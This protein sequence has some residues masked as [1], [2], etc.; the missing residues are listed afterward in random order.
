MKNNRLIKLCALLFV[1]LLANC[2]DPSEGVIVNVNT[3]TLFKAP[4]LVRFENA[5]P[6]STSRIGDFPITITGKD[7][8]LVHMGTGGTD[9]KAAQGNLPL[10]LRSTAHPTDANPVTFTINAQIPGHEPIA[11]NVVLTSDSALVYVIA[12]FDSTNPAEGTSITNAEANLKSGVT[13][14]AVKLSTSTTTKLNETATITIPSGTEVRD[15]TNKLI[16]ADALRAIVT[17]YGNST[18]ALNVAFPNGRTTQNATDKEG[19]IIPYGVNYVPAGVVKIDMYAGKS[20]VAYFS[21][22]IEINQELPTGLINYETKAVVKLGEAIPLWLSFNQNG[23]YQLQKTSATVVAGPTGK[24]TAKYAITAAAINNLSW[25]YTIAPEPINSSLE[26][27]LNPSH[28][29]FTGNYTLNALNANNTYLFVVENYQ[30]QIQFYQQG[31]IDNANTVY[32]TVRG[33]YGY[34]FPSIPNTTSMKFVVYSEAGKKVGETNLV[35]PLTTHNLTMAIDNSPVIIPEP[36][37]PPAPI[38]Y[39]KVKAN[40]I[41]KCTNVNLTSPINIWV[42]ITDKTDNSANYL[43]IKNGVID[44]ATNSIQLIIDREYTLSTTYNGQNYNSSSFK[45]GKADQVL[46]TGANNFTA[47]FIYN[48][49]TNSLDLNGIVS[50]EC[51]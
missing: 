49:A 12:A 7:A 1:V 19:D 50:Q 44:N 20:K 18:P 39:I 34:L 16:T 15:A 37:K 6:N 25:G 26:L 3:S 2:K 29:P 30:P 38:E 51:N 21:K 47:N 42:T 45:V 43:Y 35:N 4:F 5:N 32:T 9:F 23:T 27:I 17:F 24:L 28:T 36:P 10:A 33:K 46:K 48:S 40:F 11:K 13:T 41:G 31:R 14:A 8:E 22:P